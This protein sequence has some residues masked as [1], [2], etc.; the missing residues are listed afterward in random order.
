MS[1]IRLVESFTDWSE[2][3]KIR[4]LQGLQ[5]SRI[6]EH[7]GK[8][9]TITGAYL[10]PIWR[11]DK[12]NANGRTY[13]RALGE[14]VVGMKPVTLALIDHPEGDN[15]R[16]KDLAA[17]GKNPQ[18]IDG[19]LYAECHF[20]DEDFQR[21]VE[22]VLAHGG[23][24]GLSSSALGE[25]D[26]M[27]NVLEESFELERLFDFVIDP[28]Y[29]VYLDSATEGVSAPQ[30]RTEKV[31]SAASGTPNEGTKPAEAVERVKMGMSLAE[32]NFNF[33]IKPMLEKARS[34]SNPFE[35]KEAWLEIAEYC[36]NETFAAPI[37]KEAKEKIEKADADILDL[38]E[39]G[40]Q[41]EK[42]L[43]DKEKLKEGVAATEEEVKILQEALNALSAEHEA[44]LDLLEISRRRSEK[45]AMMYKLACGERNGRV[46]ASKFSKFL[47]YISFLEKE[48]KG[49]RECVKGVQVNKGRVEEQYLKTL[50]AKQKLET[51]KY[52]SML[53]EDYEA[54]IRT[55]TEP[56]ITVQAD[57][58]EEFDPQGE[59]DVPVVTD[60]ALGEV[61]EDEEL[62]F[63]EYG[64][65]DLG[66]HTIVPVM[67]TDE[68]YPERQ[69]VQDFFEDLVRNNPADAKF[70][71]HILAQRTLIQAQLKYMNLT[72]GVPSFSQERRKRVIKESTKKDPT[73]VKGG[74]SW[75]SK[76]WAGWG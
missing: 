76:S 70:R 30:R 3:G 5:E 43:E 54:R 16:L 63:S 60:P 73:A 55:E 53:D 59:T 46:R 23:K 6:V 57:S 74:T 48:N 40:L 52:K 67:D 19:D 50:Q 11:L 29:G 33:G 69:A 71:E 72:S 20:V 34:L 44:T 21:I 9:Y 28:S 18:I 7:E 66:K 10:V 39:K 2:D 25:L 42:H 4:P 1:K 47:E 15:A 58:G 32:K 26:S 31:E 38:A 36:D 64:E 17:I 14:K 37:L 12:R 56:E 22:K 41:E 24:I 13:R 8:T 49:L 62:E 65:E 68:D 51:E 35:V 61:P 27:G 75:A 45:L